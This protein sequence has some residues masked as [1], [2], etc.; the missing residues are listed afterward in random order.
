MFHAWICAPELVREQKRQVGCRMPV[1]QDDARERP[2]EAVSV[3]AGVDFRCLADEIWVVVVNNP[4]MPYRPVNRQCNSGQQQTDENVS[5]RVSNVE[6]RMRN[7]ESTMLRHSS[8]G[9]EPLIFTD[10]REYAV[11]T[12]RLRRS[13]GADVRRLV[14]NHISVLSVCSG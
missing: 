11:K 1:G 10:K 9:I 3:Q 8:K 6:C 4:A 5:A 13:V 7:A 2:R 12:L 14:R